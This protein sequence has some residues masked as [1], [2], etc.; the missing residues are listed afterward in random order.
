MTEEF[1]A[2]AQKYE[3]YI[4]AGSDFHGEMVKP[5]IQ[6]HPWKLDWIG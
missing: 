3:L 5:D 6:L 4:S 2:L 1:L